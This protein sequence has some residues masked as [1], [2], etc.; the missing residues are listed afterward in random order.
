M[1]LGKYEDFIE[2]SIKQFVIQ[3]SPIYLGQIICVVWEIK[4]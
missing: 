2:L 1:S 3:L 4:H